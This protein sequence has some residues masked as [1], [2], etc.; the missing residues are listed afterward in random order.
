MKQ[1]EDLDNKVVSSIVSN[2]VKVSSIRVIVTV[3]H[4]SSSLCTGTPGGPVDCNF[5]NRSTSGAY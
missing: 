5:V 4:Y 2:I 1:K 3:L